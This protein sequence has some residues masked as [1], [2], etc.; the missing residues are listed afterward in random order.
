MPK[1]MAGLFVVACICLLSVGVAAESP[2]AA[3]TAWSTSVGGIQD[4]TAGGCLLREDGLLLVCGTT[5]SYST[6]DSDGIIILMDP[7]DGRIIWQRPYGGLGDDGF[8][9]LA[10][11]PDGGCYA[12][13]TSCSGSHGDRDLWIVRC[14]DD[15]D[16]IW[17][18]RYGGALKDEGLSVAS[19]AD[20]GMLACGSTWSEG[21]GGSDGWLVRLGEDGGVQWSRTFGG[22]D[23]ERFFDV[24]P[25]PDGWVATGTTYSQGVHGEV[26]T[27]WT[28]PEGLETSRAV[29]GCPGYDYGRAL[30]AE[31]DGGTLVGCW[32]KGSV[33]NAALLFCDSAGTVDRALIMPTGFDTRLEDMARLPDGTLALAGCME[34]Q[35]AGDKDV[36]LWRLSS[37]CQRIGEV[38]RGGTGSERLAGMAV[39]P[40]GGL[41]LAGTTT[42]TERGDSDIW[43]L[44]LETFAEG[45]DPQRE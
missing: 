45:Q 36:F 43:L 25:S 38:V 10:A 31:E 7:A 12:V 34:C 28:D 4:E 33:C 24:Q 8:S 15:G 14:G 9:G 32:S 16:V 19:A 39:T 30:M 6:G 23:M 17:E 37:D 41:V 13:G 35:E 40:D 18:R 29:W 1:T 22:P 42:S 5:A 26:L 44:G 20:G 21:A 3:I 11:A 2:D 27:V